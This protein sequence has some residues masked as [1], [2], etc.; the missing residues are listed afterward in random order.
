MRV[1][2][3][4]IVSIGISAVVLAGATVLG[5]ALPA[6]AYGCNTNFLGNGSQANPW[7]IATSDNLDCFAVGSTWVPAGGGDAYFIQ[8][9]DVARDSYIPIS[10]T[11]GAPHFHYDGQGHTVVIENVTGY[12]GLF[13][14]TSGD[15]I[16]NLTVSSNGATLGAFTGWLTSSDTSSTFT[17]VHSVGAIGANNGGLVGNGI[18]TV[19]SNS[20]TSGAIGILSG[21]LVGLANNVTITGSSSSGL[22]GMNSGGLVGPS[23]AGVTISNSYTTGLIQPYAGGLAGQLANNITLSNVYSTGNISSNG[24]GIVGAYSHGAVITGA[25]S[26]GNIGATAGGIAGSG[27]LNAS[28]SNVYSAGPIG[29]FAGGIMGD[30]SVSPTISHAYSAQGNILG[31]NPF[32]QTVTNSLS[33]TGPFD[34]TV[35]LSVLSPVSAWAECSTLQPVGFYL[36]AITPVNPCTQAV[37]PTTPVLAQTGEATT[38]FLGVGLLALLAGG[39]SVFWSTR[40]KRGSF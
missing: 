15:Q 29:T 33:G 40:R 30:D 34:S 10:P 27:A 35:A 37:V 18:G 9:A 12:D 23:S 3:K 32:G 6:A 4:K 11:P 28:I 25:Y 2:S 22:I 26:L 17:N 13:S 20:S 16:S 38:P 8:T 39:L 1:R 5:S 21:G 14:P 31:N 7:Q 36:T 24:G 19:I